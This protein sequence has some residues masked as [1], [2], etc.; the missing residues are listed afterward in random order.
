MHLNTGGVNPG[1][2]Y[3]EYKMLLNNMQQTYSD[4]YSINEHCLDTSQPQ[5]KRELYDAGKS[6]NKFSTQ[7][8]GTSDEVFPKKYNPG[9]TMIG[10]TGKLV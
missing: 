1:N 2:S 3:V 5:I 8:F 4:I 6:A 9:G 10:I 7:I